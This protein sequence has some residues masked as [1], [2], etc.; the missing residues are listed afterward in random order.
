VSTKPA[1]PNLKTLPYGGAS[2]V[3]SPLTAMV[4][5]QYIQENS[6]AFSSENIQQRF[7]T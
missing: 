6:L 1:L 4:V 2:S 7:L 3:I 5:K